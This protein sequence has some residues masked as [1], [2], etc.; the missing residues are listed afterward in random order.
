MCRIPV[1][2]SKPLEEDPDINE[3]V[4][5]MHSGGR[6]R[7]ASISESIRPFT[8]DTLLEGSAVDETQTPLEATVE[9]EAEYDLDAKKSGSLGRRLSEPQFTDLQERENPLA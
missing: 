8:M 1:G 7:M 4:P 6:L 5:M 2:C 3:D 9:T